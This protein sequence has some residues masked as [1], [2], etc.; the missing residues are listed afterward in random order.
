MPRLVA[1]NDSGGVREL[2]CSFWVSASWNLHSTSPPSTPPKC[3]ETFPKRLLASGGSAPWIKP[4]QPLH[5]GR[6]FH[7][8]PLRDA[9]ASRQ[10]GR[11]LSM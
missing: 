5:G 7:A 9:V 11:P 3:E 1:R 10:H 2:W 6:R 4:P 8:G